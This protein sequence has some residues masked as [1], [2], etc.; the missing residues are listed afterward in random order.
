ME[1][2]QKHPGFPC[3]LSRLWPHPCQ[4]LP[5]QPVWITTLCSIL[6]FNAFRLSTY[7]LYSALTSL[8]KGDFIQC[9][10]PGHSPIPNS[11]SCC[12]QSKV[13]M[14]IKPQ[15]LERKTSNQKWHLQRFMVTTCF[16]LRTILYVSF[17]CGRILKTTGIFLLLNKYKLKLVGLPLKRRRMTTT[18]MGNRVHILIPSIMQ[19]CLFNL[20][21]S[22]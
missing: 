21:L 8:L 7:N 9:G 3:L 20:R 22:S 15:N 1:I 5:S 17:W 2:F 11:Y 13:M 14:G 10:V 16:G 6:K 12:Y 18:W 19:G 4:L